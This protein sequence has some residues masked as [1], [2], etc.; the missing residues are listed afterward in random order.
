MRVRSAT[1][2]LAREFEHG[3]ILANPSARPYEFDLE[4]LFPE[5]ALRR[6]EASPKQDATVNSGEDVHG[7]LRVPPRDAVFLITR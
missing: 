3:V 1:D 6:L 5:K 4:R 7:R 2:A